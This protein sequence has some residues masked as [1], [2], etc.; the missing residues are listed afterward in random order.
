[1]KINH[2]QNYISGIFYF[3]KFVISSGVTKIKNIIV[4]HHRHGN[5]FKRKL[6]RCILLL[7]IFNQ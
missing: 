5:G 2:K 6:V 1:M 3:F 4:S 7:P